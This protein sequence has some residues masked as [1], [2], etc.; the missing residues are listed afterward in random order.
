MVRFPLYLV[1][2][3]TVFAFVLRPVSDYFRGHFLQAHRKKDIASR[4][5]FVVG[6]K[7]IMFVQPSAHDPLIVAFHI[8]ARKR[9][10]FLCTATDV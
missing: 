8:Y 4:A 3:L 9:E 2:S 1:I 5:L 10:Q 6:I 7:L